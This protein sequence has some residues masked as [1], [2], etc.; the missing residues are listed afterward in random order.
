MT[1][2]AM[3]WDAYDAYSARHELAERYGDGE[4]CVYFWENR[5]GEPFYVGSG[6][7]YRFQQATEKCR[8]KE[9]MEVYAEG[10]CSPKIVAYGMN[11]KQARKFEKNLILAYA[12]L[13]F[14]LVNKQYLVDSTHTPARMALYERNRELAKKRRKAIPVSQEEFEK[15]YEAFLRGEC[16]A[17]YAMQQLGLEHNDYYKM[18]RAYKNEHQTA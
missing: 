7:Y 8:S 18:V 15:W 4:Y 16:K 17:K 6:K 12:E 14:P 3:N 2:R 9:F 1:Q 10:G 5:F 11:E 13:E